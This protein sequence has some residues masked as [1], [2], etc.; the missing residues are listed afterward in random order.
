MKKLM[1]RIGAVLMAVAM[2]AALGV[3]AWAD[4][5]NQSKDGTIT[6]SGL[7]TGDT[8]AFYKVL[9]SVRMLLPPV[10]GSRPRHLQALAMIS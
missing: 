10:D 4:T 7:D 9:D 5:N 1:K 8:V 6:V 2:M 3:S